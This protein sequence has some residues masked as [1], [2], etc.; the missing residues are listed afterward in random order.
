MPLD[1]ESSLDCHVAGPV[2]VAIPDCEALRTLENPVDMSRHMSFQDQ[3]L[4]LMS[5]FWD[6]TLLA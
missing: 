2:D 1:D 5:R 4:E 6:K 3:V